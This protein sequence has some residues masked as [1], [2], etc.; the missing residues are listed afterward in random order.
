MVYSE[1][2]FYFLP[3]VAFVA[4]TQYLNANARQD[5]SSDGDQSGRSA[6]SVWSPKIG[7]LWEVDPHL[8]GVWQ[9]LAQRRSA[10]LR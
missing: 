7:L 2:A 3:K 1:N 8:A 6:F 5:R 10:E 4:G 9:H